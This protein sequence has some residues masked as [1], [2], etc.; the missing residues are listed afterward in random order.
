MIAV[1]SID[2]KG[3][4]SAQ[5]VNAAATVAEI[6]I[7]EAELRAILVDLEARAKYGKME[8]VAVPLLVHAKTVN[9]DIRRRLTFASG[10]TR[11]RF[12]PGFAHLTGQLGTIALAL[13]YLGRRHERVHAT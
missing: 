8:G 5:R 9:D 12:E 7:M 6:E 10:A 4:E 1:K 3:R 11:E 13:A 2:L